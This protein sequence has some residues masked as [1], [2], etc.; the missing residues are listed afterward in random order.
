LEY[1]DLGKTRAQSNP[2]I[3]T[4]PR[5]GLVQVAGRVWNGIADPE[6]QST[7]AKSDDKVSSE[8]FDDNLQAANKALANLTAWTKIEKLIA[9]AVVP[10]GEFDHPTDRSEDTM[11]RAARMSKLDILV[12]RLLNPGLLLR[13]FHF[14][15]LLI[16]NVFAFIM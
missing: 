8:G 5:D 15:F 2:S 14:R 9:G 13:I 1:E 6:I 4:Q 16:R 11:V 12:I 10:T 3:P 7:Y